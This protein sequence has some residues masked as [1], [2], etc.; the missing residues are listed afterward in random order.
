MI[1]CA[2]SHP[3]FYYINLS[4]D[5][6]AFST[7]LIESNFGIGTITSTDNKFHHAQNQQATAWTD[8]VWRG[9]V[10][11]NLGSQFLSMYDTSGALT[12]WRI[13]HNTVSYCMRANSGQGYCGSISNQGGHGMTPWIYNNL[14]QQAW[15]DNSV[16]LLQP[17]SNIGSP[18]ITGDYNLAFDPDGSVS[19]TTPWTSQAHPQTNIDPK[20]TNVG[21]LDFSLQSASGARGT[22]GP[23]TTANGSGSSSTTLIVATN[24]GSFFIGNNS[25]NLPQYG[26]ALVPGDFLTVGSCT[27]QVSSIS[28][29]TI[30]LASACTWA[31]ADPVYYGP[32]TTIDI[33]AY[34]YKA[35][36]YTLSGTYT[37]GGGTA[38]IVPN[39]N[40]LVR[41]VVCYDSNVPTAIVNA[42]PYTCAVGS[43]TFKATM[44][45]RYPS[46]TQSVDASFN[47]GSSLKALR[48]MVIRGIELW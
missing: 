24:T 27:A 46:Q 9:N 28:N 25:T 6:L 31:N 35:G 36:G 29:D 40:S 12:N 42:S 4:N 17:Y 7:A 30:T 13:Y 3:D 45:P 15:S 8:D 19:F 33:G 48:N 20:L 21:G 44:Y 37:I 41:F 47:N 1:Q 14:Y 16:S 38:T 32:S 39:D 5:N 23:L 10:S 2:G 11:Y 43:G 22:G 34:P 18:T 26:G